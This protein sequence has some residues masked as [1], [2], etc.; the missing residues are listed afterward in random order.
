MKI[1]INHIA[2][3][4]GHLGFE[5]ELLRGNVQSA[6]VM[7][8]EGARLFEGILIGRNYSEAGE[9]TSRI[10][11]ICPI[12]HNLT[13]IKAVET[14]MGVKA[15]KQTLLLRKLMMIGQIIQSHSMHVYFLS[16]P[17]FLGIIDDLK[18]LDKY[19]EL[20]KKALKLRDYGNRIGDVVG[21]RSI[22]PVTTKIGGFHSFPSKSELKKLVTGAEDMVAIAT[23]II[24]FVLDA[25]LPEFERESRY[26]A[27][28]K[29]KSYAIC[30]GETTSNDGVVIPHD[31]F[32]SSV[33]ELPIVYDPVHRV[34]YKTEGFLV[35]A[36]A[37]LHLS[38]SNL[39]TRAKKILKDS[40]I[41]IP[42]FN[43]FH[44]IIAQGIEIL[45]L[46]E[47]V[48]P[49]VAK[50]LATD[51]EKGNVKVKIKAGKG[52]GAMEAPRGTL[53]HYYEIDKDGKIV[54]CNIIP[55]TAMMLYNI[56]RD[57]EDYLKN[58]K[59]DDIKEQKMKIRALIRAYD[60]CISCAT[61]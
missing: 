36:M 38:R 27:L 41:E 11:G 25:K 51:L 4:E 3:T 55:P 47:E 61:H 52:I 19:P 42:D 9:I 24:R 12:V 34:T 1:T 18:L 29:K 43:P 15:T 54:D 46:L 14:A 13:A 31:K 8:K 5:S 7:V 59:G 48:K 58:I 45:H 37:R 32:Q 53:Y 57:L 33:K 16:L 30:D 6:K 44:N 21:G 10:C 20:T 35:G 28:A 23:E 50:L 2:K 60:P 17:D 22:H 49:V 40:P 56:E 39:N 26:F